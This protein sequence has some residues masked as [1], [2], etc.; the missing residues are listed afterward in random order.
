M[1]NYIYWGEQHE[2]QKQLKSIH[3]GHIFTCTTFMQ[4]NSL[5]Y[6]IKQTQKNMMTCCL[7]FEKAAIGDTDLPV[8]S[9]IRTLYP[10]LPILLLS[11]PLTK[12]DKI[13][14]LKAG[15]DSVTPITISMEELKKLVDFTILYKSKQI[16]RTIKN[17]KPDLQI[18][19]LPLW[20]RIFD[21]LS[22]SV[23]I[24]LLS[25]VFLT[26]ALLIRLE[27][28]GKVIYKSKRVGSNYRI[29]NFYK[30][31]SM[32]A[33]ADQRLS[34]Y[35][36]LNQYTLADETTT[37]AATAPTIQL[38]NNKHSEVILFSDDDSTTEKDYLKIKKTEQSNAFFKLE[39]DPRITRVGKIIRKY[40]ID[41]LPQLFNILEGDMSVVGN[42]PLPLYEAELLTSDEYIQRFMAPAGLTGLWQVEKR[43]N[44]GNMS[45]EE[46]KLL[47]IKYAQTFSFWTDIKLIIRT[48]TSFIQKEDV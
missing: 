39:N 38:P 11:Q 7:L 32:Y 27:S 3:G 18:F 40:S 33:D 29:F 23:A 13:A 2:F 25:P 19:K 35:K 36:K 12:E 5:F 10:D 16:N 24:L 37:P 20:K 14:Y 9:K 1:I 17:G 15:I 46:R 26:T 28:Q 41:E 8:L 42:R 31:R 44:S 34:E 4:L 48:F 43:G 45:A 22:S 47:D 30:F 6:S 21:I